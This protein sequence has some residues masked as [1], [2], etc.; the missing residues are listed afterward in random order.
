MFTNIYTKRIISRFLDLFF[1]II[2]ASITY[3]ITSLQISTSNF[4]TNTIIIYSGSIFYIISTIYF[5]IKYKNQ[6]LGDIILKIRAIPFTNNK[7]NPIKLILKEL[8]ILILLLNA[9]R[10]S[11]GW[12]ILILLII[13]VFNHKKLQNTFVLIDFGFK[14]FY[15]DKRKIDNNRVV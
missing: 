3:Y 8:L 15:E 2:L 4:D 1:P 13:P 5:V 6:T 11:F 7:V 9:L 14:F 10:N 12:F